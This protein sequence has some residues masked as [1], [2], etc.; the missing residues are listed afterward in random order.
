MVL[1]F[2]SIGIFAQKGNIPIV[3]PQPQPSPPPVTNPSN[4]YSLSRMNVEVWLEDNILTIQFYQS[5]GDA[6][7]TLNCGD[8][9]GFV[10]LTFSTDAPIAI[11]LTPYGEVSSFTIGTSVDNIYIGYL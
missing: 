10:D 9:N 6:T 1:V 3:Q 2:S 11:D 5:E 7:I 8:G 4:P